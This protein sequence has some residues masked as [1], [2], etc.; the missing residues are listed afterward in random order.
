[1][2][3]ARIM[4]PLSILY[5]RLVSPGVDVLARWLRRALSI[6]YLR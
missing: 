2:A 6:L 5:L 3:M 1:M 4:P